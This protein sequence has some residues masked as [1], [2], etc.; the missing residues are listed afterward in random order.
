M[1]PRVLRLTIIAMLVAVAVI[2]E[3]IASVRIA[4]AGVEGIRI[5]LGNF[6]IVF[7]AVIF[8]PWG[9]ATVG[10]LEDL[11]GY[12]INPAGAYMPH[13]T[14]TSA[15]MGF[16]PGL[17]LKGRKFPVPGIFHL[18][19]SIGIANLVVTLGLTPYFLLTLFG[20]PR[21]TTV[22]PR[23]IQ[24][25]VEV[26]LYTVLIRLILMRLRVGGVLSRLERHDGLSQNETKGQ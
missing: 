22:P 8:G 23:I 11:I 1:K 3:R 2:L 10:A 16:I 14:L 18:A 5:G 21:I 4:F 15:L 20:I 17:V 26:F 7:S 25:V 9:G 12:F 13:F 6:P 24:S 19:I